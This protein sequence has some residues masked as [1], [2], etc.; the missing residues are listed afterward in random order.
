[1]NINKQ[2]LICLIKFLNT[3][4]NVK[5]VLNEHCKEEY[6]AEFT[7]DVLINSDD[8]VKISIAFS[9][10]FPLTLPDF[11]VRDDI[12]FRA[13]VGSKGKLCLFDSS[14]ILIKKELPEQVIIDC[15]DQAVEILKIQPGSKTYNDEVCR[16]FD[17]YWLSVMNKKT[18]SCLELNGIKYGEYPMVVANGV[19]VIAN[20]KN[21]AEVILRNNF[22]FAL[23]EDSFERS[24]LIFKIR[25]GSNM[26]PL[27]KHFKWNSLRR[28]ILHNTTS[29]V[30][31]QFQKFLDKKVKHYVRYLLLIYPAKE[32]DIFFGFRV[33]FNSTRY[34]KIG[35]SLTC[36]IENTFIERIDNSY[37]T[38]RGGATSKLKDKRVLL[39][40]CGSVGGYIASNLCQSGVMNLDILDN[41]FFQPENL[42]RHWLGFDS[43]S[44]KA[45]NYKADLVKEKLEAQ[46]PYVDIDS[47]NY[48]DRSAQT[49]IL[50][51]NKLRNYDLIISALG[52]PT[53]NLEINRILEK[54]DIQV[55]FM[56][57][58]NEP[59]GIGGHVIAV[60][61]DKSS[62][63]QCLYTD[64][65]S[66]EITQFKGS[67]VA[68]N[69]NFKKNISG[70]SGSF[71]PYSCLDTQ[72]TALLA[73][74]KAIDILHGR[75]IKNSLFSWIGSSD[76]FINTK[77]KLAE[78]YLLNKENSF[79]SFDSFAN[80]HCTIHKNE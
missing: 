27:S 78:W 2:T 73:T 48:I 70:C 8:N 17:S 64:S 66:S 42:H 7:G 80:T 79:V 25:D 71:V 31:R 10:H 1:M 49:F 74:R 36:K 41:D 45:L 15:Y 65:I 34:C 53:I 56:V 9:Q 72:Q 47:L 38:M 26:I 33:E 55:P 16:E 75:L 39:L 60:N 40:G 69:Q 54:S 21:D 62:C 23:D 11:Y 58:F 14:S 4:R 51:V 67:F 32:G 3:E 37:L 77:F 61:I 35:S 44:T 19:S 30:K 57:C 29:S 46:Y 63:L 68:P 43:L 6:I 24:C 59:Y 5:F 20:T 18:Y 50:D 12:N 22:G 76:I 52:E 13:H 28:Y